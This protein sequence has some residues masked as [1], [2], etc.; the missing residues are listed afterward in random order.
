[1]NFVKPIITMTLC[2]LFF[3][4][5]KE[6]GN[7]PNLSESTNAIGSTEK[8]VAQKPETAT[9][10]IDGMT[11]SMGCAKTI[12]R[13]LTEMEGVQEAK[14]DFD[15]K[16]QRLVLTQRFYLPKKSQK[17]LKPQP[18]VKLIKSLM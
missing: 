7:K 12:E 3:M 5:C 9:L 2:S 17:R 4:S 6:T 15:K 10:K 16:K 18:M 8:K 13:K 11:C 14:V 1:M